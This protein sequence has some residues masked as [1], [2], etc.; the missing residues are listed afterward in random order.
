[1]IL[2]VQRQRPC[3]PYLPNRQREGAPC[4][5][6]SASRRANMSLM[7][8]GIFVVALALAGCG[9]DQAA[10]GAEDERFI[11]AMVELRRAGIE[12]GSDTAMFEEL[13]GR[14]LEE[15]GVT[16]EALRAYVDSRAGRLDHMAAIWDSIGA[17]LTTPPPQ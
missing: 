15:Q 8:R 9:P 5:Y 3:P 11:A 6:R 16:E 2:P 7:R 13:R 1:M 4:L 14:I 10:L 17:R 12:A